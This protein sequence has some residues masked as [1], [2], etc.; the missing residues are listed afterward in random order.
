ME[1]TLESICK[2]WLETDMSQALIAVK[3]DVAPSF[4]YRVVVENF[5]VEQRIAKR[6]IV[7]R[8]V[9]TDER[10]APPSWYTGPGRSVPLKIVEYCEAMGITEIPE[11]MS[12][13]RLP[14]GAFALMTRGDA[15]LLAEART[16]ILGG[17]EA[18]R[19]S[20][21]DYEAQFEEPNED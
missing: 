17:G 2:L 3:C 9:Q 16:V 10:V 6:S 4:V 11:G 8:K 18:S 7:Q 12:V 1:E 20:L 15:K 14:S 21:S 13:V 5:T 19:Q